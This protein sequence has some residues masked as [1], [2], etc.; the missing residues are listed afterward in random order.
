MTTL[1]VVV[2]AAYA[3]GMLAMTHCYLAQRTDD[4]SRTI[5]A[6]TL[7][8]AAEQRIRPNINPGADNHRRLRV[9]RLLR[10]QT[11]FPGLRSFE[12]DL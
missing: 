10:G 12:A 8:D 3:V 4:E 1:D 2:I 6:S 9:S 5:G 7:V 11:Q